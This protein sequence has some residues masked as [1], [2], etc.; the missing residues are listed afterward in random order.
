M[1]EIPRFHFEGAG[2][3]QRAAE[4]EAISEGFYL[5]EGSNQPGGHCVSSPGQTANLYLRD[6][7]LL[8]VLSVITQRAFSSH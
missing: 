5:R 4:V 3:C 8:H 2:S 7:H 6:A 1:I